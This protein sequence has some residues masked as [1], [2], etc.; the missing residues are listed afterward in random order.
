MINA[1]A[2]GGF[3]LCAVVDNDIAL[4]N[5]AA[6]RCA[7]A[8]NGTAALA[9]GLHR[10][11]DGQRVSVAF[12][13][14][15][16]ALAA[17]DHEI[18]PKS[19]IRQRLDCA[20][21]RVVGRIFNRTVLNRHRDADRQNLRMRI[22]AA[23]KRMTA[24]VKDEVFRQTVNGGKRI[25]EAGEILEK[26]ELCRAGEDRLRRLAAC[27]FGR[28]VG[29]GDLKDRLG[30][31]IV[32]AIDIQ[33]VSVRHGKRIGV[34][35]AAVLEKNIAARIACAADKDRSLILHRSAG[36]HTEPFG[37][38]RNRQ[39]YA[40]GNGKRGVLG[41]I[42]PDVLRDHEIRFKRIVRA[43]Y[44]PLVA[45]KMCRRF[46]RGFI[47]RN[48]RSG[49]ARPD[50]DR[51]ILI[52]DAVSTV[53]IGHRLIPLGAVLFLHRAGE[54][55][56]GNGNRLSRS[57][58]NG[59]GFRTRCAIYFAAGYVQRNHER[60]A[61]IVADFA[62]GGGVKALHLAARDI[63]RHI[64]GIAD[65]RIHQNG[66][67]VIVD[68]VRRGIL[69]PDNV[70]V[71]GTLHKTA[72]DVQ[73]AGLDADA[74][75]AAHRAAD[76]DKA[77]LRK[78]HG[79][80]VR[81]YRCAAVNIDVRGVLIR[82]VA[83]NAGHSGRSNFAVNIQCLDAAI[84]VFVQDNC[85]ISRTVHR[86]NGRVYINGN[87]SAGIDAN[88]RRIFRRTLNCHVL[89]HDRA[90]RRNCAAGIGGC[91]RSV[92]ECKTA[93]RINGEYRV[94][95]GID[96]GHGLAVQVKKDA[97]AVH[98][99]GRADRHILQQG[100]RAA[101]RYCRHGFRKGLILRFANGCLIHRFLNGICS[102]LPG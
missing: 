13:P 95:I 52:P 8:G 87:L 22:A 77:F 59:D 3:D 93:A 62:D 91:H 92:H 1:D 89:E 11:V 6:D 83:L 7:V 57:A 84:F 49:K 73:R 74:A 16:V 100:N 33:N 101:V 64:S 10:A 58:A 71:R 42:Q 82:A 36:A 40:G 48:F 85:G 81:R 75:V 34:E 102:V 56:A 4:G 55:S 21:F 39:R 37:I 80:L 41:N 66:G 29:I 67:A 88:Q 5:V 44:N 17:A 15:A 63:D 98:G 31:E 28:S 79:K 14:Y 9:L 18:A 32:G 51:E 76:I 45:V 12:R 94:G 26:R 27:L 30:R 2:F 69:V 54:C 78:I 23:G 25:S 24:E 99:N 47:A 53:G 46:C 43:D 90:A 61:R 20:V 96:A 60:F 72:A 86:D 38:R 70:V 68:T 19:D 35:R 97:L 65:V 50:L